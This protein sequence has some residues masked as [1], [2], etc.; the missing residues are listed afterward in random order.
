VRTAVQRNRRKTIYRVL[1]VVF[2]L[3]GVVHAVMALMGG[4]HDEAYQ[5]KIDIAL[6]W[7]LF[8]ATWVALSRLWGELAEMSAAAKQGSDPHS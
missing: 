7:L 1:S 6:L 8:G 5:T 3:I 2:V 4:I